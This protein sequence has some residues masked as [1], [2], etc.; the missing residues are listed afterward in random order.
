MAWGGWGGGGAIGGG[1][2]GH[3]GT[4]GT[5][6]PFGGIPTELMELL[7]L[8]P[9]IFIPPIFSGSVGWLLT[10]LRDSVNW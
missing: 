10:P 7:C 8:K 9:I 4:A 5:G 6:L 2:G 3:P 1:F